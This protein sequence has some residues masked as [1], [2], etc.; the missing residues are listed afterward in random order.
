[1]ARQTALVNIA[2]MAVVLVAIITLPAGWRELAM[3][4]RRRCILVHNEEIGCM[5]R[6]GFSFEPV[7]EVCVGVPRHLRHDEAR[8]STMW[9]R[10]A[11]RPR[12]AHRC[13]VLL[14]STGLLSG[15]L[16]NAPTY[17]TFLAAAF[18]LEHLSLED[19][20]THAHLVDAHGHYLIAISVASVFFGA[21]T[22]IGNAPESDGQGTLR[23]CGRA[24]AV[25]FW[26][27][28]PVFAARA[29]PDSCRRRLA[30]FPR[31]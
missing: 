16:D 20:Q 19:P 21:L 13:P 28:F 25:I 1:M 14:G 18:G 2:Y 10:H 3:V 24:H 12:A 31:K 15:V 9:V 8:Y 29:H 17:L 26:L 22:Y 6:T 7:R 27:R 11:D 5:K 30:F 4:R 23:S